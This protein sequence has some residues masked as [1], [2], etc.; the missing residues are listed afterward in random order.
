[1]GQTPLLDDPCSTTTF[2]PETLFIDSYFL[3]IFT[4]HHHHRHCHCHQKSPQFHPGLREPAIREDREE[5]SV[6]NSGV[7]P[8]PPPRQATSWRQADITELPPRSLHCSERPTHTAHTP[9]TRTHT[10]TDT[11]AHTHVDTHARAHTRVGAGGGQRTFPTT[12][13][14][15]ELCC[16]RHQV[17]ERT[18]FEFSRAEMFAF[19][20]ARNQTQRQGI[21]AAS[22]VTGWRP[23]TRT[24]LD[25]PVKLQ[26]S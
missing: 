25:K 5:E 19:N 22:V 16:S 6:L 15:R 8:H 7:P 3:P 26:P 1:M 23:P 2:D 11:H 12:P 21:P 14:H 9:H 20:R 4:P 17:A 10:R 13:W 24:R 18:R